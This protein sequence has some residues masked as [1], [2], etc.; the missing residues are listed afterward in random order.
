M[1]ESPPIQTTPREGNGDNDRIVPEN[2]QAMT[3]EHLVQILFGQSEE[4]PIQ[5][6]D[7]AIFVRG[8]NFLKKWLVVGRHNQY[9]VDGRLCPA[10]ITGQS[11]GRGDL[12]LETLT[13]TMDAQ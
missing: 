2:V 9:L 1:V 8:D 13:G 3:I 4:R 11:E 7:E 6:E 10:P 12:A 5:R